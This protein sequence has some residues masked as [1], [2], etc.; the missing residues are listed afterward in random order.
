MYNHNSDRGAWLCVKKIMKWFTRGGDC[1]LRSG[2]CG[3]FTAQVTGTNQISFCP[4][5]FYTCTTQKKS[6]H[7]LLESA[8][9]APPPS[10]CTPCDDFLLGLH[11]GCLVLTLQMSP[12]QKTSALIPSG[13]WNMLWVQN[14]SPVDHQYS[15]MSELPAFAHRA[16]SLAR[17]NRP[18]LMA[19]NRRA[20]D[21]FV[22]LALLWPSA[23]P[24]PRVVV[25][26]IQSAA[27]AFVC[28]KVCQSREICLFCPISSWLLRP[29]FFSSLHNFLE[30]FRSLPEDSL[31]AHRFASR[32]LPSFAPRAQR[33]ILIFRLCL[34][35]KLF[36]E[37]LAA[38]AAGSAHCLIQRHQINHER[39]GQPRW[40][41]SCRIKIT[42]IRLTAQD[43][44]LKV[45]AR[46]RGRNSPH[47]YREKVKRLKISR[48][49]ASSSDNWKGTPL[50]NATAS[51][52][53]HQTWKSFS[54]RNMIIEGEWIEITLFL[55]YF[56]WA[57]LII[58][59]V[60]RESVRTHPKWCVVY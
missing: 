16:S 51:W 57:F 47:S 53:S 60:E 38:A 13:S 27:A 34:P 23:C 20:R 19:Y 12:N 30:E 25:W 1:S 41:I 22:Q 36:W 11:E 10:N 4:F 54:F 15:T 31:R 58:V 39:S 42:S 26:M 24:S 3:C 56:S 37:Q 55:C 49:C 28:T 21:G 2:L 17:K 9:R 7:Y 29:G 59:R 18:G 5:V 14:H 46:S 35:L 33:W 44:L 48:T 6:W 40:A 50:A 43:S 45:C 8:S 52:I 32:A